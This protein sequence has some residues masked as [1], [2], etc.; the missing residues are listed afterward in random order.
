V[1]A[2]SLCIS[3]IDPNNS[4][5][6]MI[7]S[8]WCCHLK[9]EGSNNTIK[10]YTPPILQAPMLSAFTYH[11]FI[12]RNNQTITC[13]S[14]PPFLR[15]IKLFC[16]FSLVMSL[17]RPLGLAVF[18]LPNLKQKMAS[19]QT[20][21]SSLICALTTSSFGCCLLCAFACACATP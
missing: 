13:F 8:M 10:H 7:E 12:E 14:L 18:S 9:Y 3:T 15:P 20:P 16:L 6:S 21:A 1:V 5:S 4:N 11:C 17:V 19:L 2:V